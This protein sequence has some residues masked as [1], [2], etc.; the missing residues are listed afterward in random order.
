MSDCS[1]VHLPADPKAIFG[2][3]ETSYPEVTNLCSVYLKIIGELIY[4]AVNT[5]PDISYIVNPLAQHNAQSETCHYAAAKRVLRYLAGTLDLHLHYQS[6][7]DD[8]QLFAYADASWANE[9][10]RR[11]VSG[12]AWY[13]AGGLISH[14]SKKQPTIT[15]SSTKAEYIALTHIIQ[16]G[17]WLCSLLAELNIPFVSPVPLYLDNSGAITLS[18]TAKFHQHTKH[19]D[20][21]Y[22]FIRFH[23]DN[24]SFLLIWVPSHHNIADI[25][26]K[27]LPRPAFNTLCSSIGLVPR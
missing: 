27:A 24:R 5:C 10:G 8:K 17:L 21:L 1:P 25:L 18:T 22:H 16:E 13:Y 9:S 14:V 20:I 11:S 19:I 3:A 2:L 12:Y 7:T 23:I 6:D 4:L 26:T 15:L